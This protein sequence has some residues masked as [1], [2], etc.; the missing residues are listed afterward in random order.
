[1]ICHVNV[2]QATCDTCNLVGP[3]ATSQPELLAV[4]RERGWTVSDIEKTRGPSCRAHTALFAQVPL[5]LLTDAL[6][7]ASEV[8]DGPPL[9][10]PSFASFAPLAPPR[11]MVEIEMSLRRLAEALVRELEFHGALLGPDGIPEWAVLTM[12]PL[13][14]WN[15]TLIR[16]TNLLAMLANMGE[17]ESAKA[18]V[19]ESFRVPQ[20]ITG[21]HG[22][23]VFFYAPAPLPAAPADVPELV[24]VASERPSAEPRPDKE[25]P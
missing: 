15:T 24:A 7:E 16:R 18:I 9:G 25:A 20:V 1:M 4:A 5:G 12:Q 13:G 14:G 21:R 22:I 10:P 17:H 3:I 2:W 11:V 19:Q 6:S 23:S 8:Y